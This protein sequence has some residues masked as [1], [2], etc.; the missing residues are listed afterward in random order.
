MD[1]L[2]SDVWLMIFQLLIDTSIDKILSARM[3]IS[4]KK[5]N[6]RFNTIVSKNIFW[7]SN[8]KKD[9]SLNIP[10]NF[11]YTSYFKAWRHIK[12]GR[13]MVVICIEQNYEQFL[14]RLIKNNSANFN[15]CLNRVIYSEKLNLLE[16][17][18]PDMIKDGLDVWIRQAIYLKRINVLK[19]LV[20]KGVDFN[21]YPS[22]SNISPLLR[23]KIFENNC[24][25][26]TKKGLPCMNKT[27]NKYC[28]VHI[29]N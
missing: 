6:K 28:E 14:L 27:T 4:W 17:L 22:F 1:Q 11:S 5:I 24:Q 9:I 13:N 29:K 12:D 20:S 23:K 21:C 16:Y 8:Y 26:K 18:Y 10:N 2:P 7:L 15:V 19:F 3:I 25:G